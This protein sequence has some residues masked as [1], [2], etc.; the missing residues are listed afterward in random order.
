MAQNCVISN[1]SN[2]FCTYDYGSVI[3]IDISLDL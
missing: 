1:V 2:K 3:S